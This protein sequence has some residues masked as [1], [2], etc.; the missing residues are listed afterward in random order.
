MKILIVNTYDRGGA[1]NSC[2][3]LHLGLLLKEIDSKVLLKFKQNDWPKS[4]TF[5][6]PAIKLSAQQRIK[7]KLKRVLKELKIY[8]PKPQKDIKQDFLN[9]REQGLE[10]FSFPNSDFD[11]TETDLYKEADVINLHWAANFLDFESFFKKNDSKSRKLAAQ[12]KL[13]TSASLYKSVTVISTLELGK[14]YNSKACSLLFR[15]S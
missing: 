13:I 11:I 5:L 12:C 7:F 10:L 1:A 9:N 8:S 4:S 3:R 14:L 15:K 2:K 6:N